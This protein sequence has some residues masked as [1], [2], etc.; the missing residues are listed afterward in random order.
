MTGFCTTIDQIS[1]HIAELVNRGVY[2]RGEISNIA[3]H[4]CR[5]FGITTGTA[6]W[7]ARHVIAK[8]HAGIAGDQL[9]MGTMGFSTVPSAQAVE[10]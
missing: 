10:S 1:L 5:E 2:A 8:N 7:I 4:V 9:P 3:T 6:T